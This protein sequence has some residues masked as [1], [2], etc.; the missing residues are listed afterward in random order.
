M[1]EIKFMIIKIKTMKI[2]NQSFWFYKN[3]LCFHWN[4][5]WEMK[6][7]IN[8]WFDKIYDLIWFDK[9]EMNQNEIIQIS[10]EFD[11]IINWWWWY[12]FNEISNQCLYSFINQSI[13]S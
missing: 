7:S 9:N 2:I 4:K 11:W 6:Q 10:N 1:N 12:Y 8:N 13:I 3:D 5:K